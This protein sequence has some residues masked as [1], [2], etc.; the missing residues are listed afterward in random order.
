MR[1]T[2]REGMVAEYPSAAALLAAVARCASAATGCSTRT[3]PT[4]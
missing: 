4:R 3:R 1:A 2:V